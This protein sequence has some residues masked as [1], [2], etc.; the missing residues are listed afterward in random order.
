MMWDPPGRPRGT[1]AV[2]LPAGVL[3]PGV[4][5]GRRRGGERG[6]S[7]DVTDDREGF[8]KGLVHPKHL[9]PTLG[10]LGRLLHQRVLVL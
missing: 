6:G 1:R 4:V 7:V 9:V 10:L 2:F 3:E 8:F 5:H